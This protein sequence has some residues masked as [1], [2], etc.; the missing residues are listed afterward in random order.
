MLHDM[1]LFNYGLFA[2]WTMRDALEHLLSDSGPAQKKVKSQR[3]RSLC[4]IPAAVRL[5]EVSGELMYAWDD[6][7]EHS[8]TK[9]P[10]GGGPLWS[11]KHGF[12]KER[13]QLWHER[14]DELSRNDGIERKDRYGTREVADVMSAIEKGVRW[15]EQSRGLAS[16]PVLFAL[17]KR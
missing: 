12:C 5:I 7:F 1:I 8:P 16:K 17:P 3:E 10:G 14:F 4:S 15:S 6:E 13:W 9:A 11:G 2:L